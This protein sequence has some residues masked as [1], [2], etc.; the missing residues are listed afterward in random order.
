M[1]F[2]IL[3]IPEIHCFQEPRSKEFF[4]AL[5]GVG[6]LRFFENEVIQAMI[7]FQW[8]LVKEYT[9]KVLLVPFILQLTAFILFANAF[10]PRISTFDDDDERERYKNG[11]YFLGAL[12]FGLS[13]YSLSNE[14]VQLYRSGLNYFESVWNF[15]DVTLPILVAVS[16]SF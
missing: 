10:N 12:L 6:N 11:A 8:P 1:K 13:L 5:A 15:L 16:T 4:N 9:I 14:C 2:K 7:D 3:D